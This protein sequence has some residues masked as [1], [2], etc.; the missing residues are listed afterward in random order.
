M[1]PEYLDDHLL[2]EDRGDIQGARTRRGKKMANEA[3]LD[4][5]KRSGDD[6][7]MIDGHLSYITKRCTLPLP[8]ILIMTCAKS[9]DFAGWGDIETGI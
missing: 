2:E 7:Q 9:V 8:I 6:F 5:L 1:R 4:L 3:L